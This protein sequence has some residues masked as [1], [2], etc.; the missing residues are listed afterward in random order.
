[1]KEIDTSIAIQI[2]PN[3]K[4]NDALIRAAGEVIK[5]KNKFYILK[6]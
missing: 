6:F 2:L 3:I 5:L 1:M 4:N